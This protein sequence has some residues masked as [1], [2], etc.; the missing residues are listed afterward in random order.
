MTGVERAELTALRE[1]FRDEMSTF[2]REMRDEFEGVRS[3]VRPA[4]IFYQRATGILLVGGAAVGLLTAASA[5]V[6]IAKAFSLL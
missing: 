6:S 2:R 1:E 5:L 4:L 3:E